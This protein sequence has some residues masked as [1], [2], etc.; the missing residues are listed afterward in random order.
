MHLRKDRHVQHK[1][2]LKETGGDVVQEGAQWWQEEG[3]HHSLDVRSD[4]NAQYLGW[5]VIGTDLLD[6]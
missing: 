1:S 3:P 2:L 5:A 6:S 4:S